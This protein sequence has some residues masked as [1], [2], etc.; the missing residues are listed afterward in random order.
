MGAFASG[1]PLEYL[2]LLH[3]AAK[4]TSVLIQLGLGVE[5]EGNDKGMKNGMLLIYGKT[6]AALLLPALKLLVA[7][8]DIEYFCLCLKVD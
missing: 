3:P 4:V 2:A 8:L 1:V 7:T 6:Q 5:V